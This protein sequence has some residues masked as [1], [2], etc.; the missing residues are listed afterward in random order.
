MNTGVV[1]KEEYRVRMCGNRVLQPAS[2]YKRRDAK[3][4]VRKFKIFKFY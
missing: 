1:P 4:I 3:C 2:E